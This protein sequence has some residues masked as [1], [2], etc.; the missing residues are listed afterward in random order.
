MPT[1]QTR[2]HEDVYSLHQELVKMLNEDGVMYRAWL[3][4][5]EAQEFQRRLKARREKARKAQREG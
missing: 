5:M 4:N 1:I 2:V 3:A